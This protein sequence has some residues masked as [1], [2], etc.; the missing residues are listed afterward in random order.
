MGIERFWRGLYNYLQ[1][2]LVERKT[3]PDREI[4]SRQKSSKHLEHQR[5]WVV[6][7]LEA[8]DSTWG[9]QAT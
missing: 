1:R 2:L 7:T 9:L 5:G 6:H 4:K 8:A 3:L